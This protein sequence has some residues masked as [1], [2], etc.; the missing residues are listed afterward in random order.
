MI[1]SE[2]WE[3]NNYVRKSLAVEGI[4]RTETQAKASKSLQFGLSEST[5]CTSSTNLSNPSFSFE[6]RLTGIP[7]IS[8]IESRP[9]R[10][11]VNDFQHTKRKKGKLGS[12]STP[13]S[14]QS[15]SQG[16]VKLSVNI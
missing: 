1:R 11:L 13:L 10:L 9:Y 6:V 2:D 15:Q 14:A 12:T 4:D 16:L 7:G 8:T 5:T 3:Q